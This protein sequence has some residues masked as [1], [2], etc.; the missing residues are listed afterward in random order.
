MQNA[1]TANQS[2][3]VAIIGLNCNSVEKIIVDSDLKVEIAND[4]SPYAN[5][6]FGY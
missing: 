1:Y 6:N 4:N 5:S 3:M 2:G